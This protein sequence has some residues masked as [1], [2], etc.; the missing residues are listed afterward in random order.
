MVVDDDADTLDMLS[1]A[2]DF[3]GGEAITASS[4]AEA[5]GLI[6]DWKPMIVF[7]DINMPGEDGYSLIR[8]IKASTAENVAAIPFVALTA[9]ARPEDS[10]KALSAGFVRH[11]PKPVDLEKVVNTILEFCVKTDAAV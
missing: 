11:M 10:E 9:M 6:A 3:L 7:S 1:F 5:Y 8:S 4:A 2:I